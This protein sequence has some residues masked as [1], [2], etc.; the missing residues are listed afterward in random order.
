MFVGMMKTEPTYTQKFSELSPWF[1]QIFTSVKNDLRDEH[2][3]IDKN[4][5][6][7]NFPGKVINK[8]EVQDL[9]Q[10]Y[11]KLIAKGFEEL[12][13]FIANRWLLRH[14]EIYNFFEEEL[15]KTHERFDQ[16]E[17]LEEAIARPLMEEAMQKFGAP[18]AYIFSILNCVAFPHSILNELKL[19]AAKSSSTP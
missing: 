12:S 2:L 5:F 10:V 16:V 7:R 3:K 4:F 18:D 8:L 6:K 11:S 9:I 1:T 19:H 14:L 17:V 15:K 13:E